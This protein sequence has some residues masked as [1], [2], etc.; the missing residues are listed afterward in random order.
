MQPADLNMTTTVTGHQLFLFVTFDNAWTD[1]EID[2][3]LAEALD[4]LGQGMENIHDVDGPPSDEAFEGGP[5]PVAAGGGR[6]DYRA[7]NRPSGSIRIPRAYTAGMRFSGTAQE[8]RD[9]TASVGRIA[10]RLGGD[11]SWGAE[12][13]KLH[14][15]RH[16]PVRL[17][18]CLA[19]RAR[20]KVPVGGSDP[21]E[22]DRRLVG[23]GL[24]A[25]GEL[26][27]FPGTTRTRT[28]L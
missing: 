15:L 19:A 18:P 4:L 20:G 7:A 5:V 9:R 13:A 22:Q 16:G 2:G 23:N 1:G 17:R 6:A 26:L 12:A 10:G 14:Q 28:W 11:L 21:L 25:P 27:S 3:E 24:H 8:V